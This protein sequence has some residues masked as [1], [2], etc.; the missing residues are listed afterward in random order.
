VAR[1]NSVC[2]MFAFAVLATAASPDENRMISARLT[3]LTPLQHTNTPLDLTIDFGQ[4]INQADRSGV[5][6]P[7]SIEVID[8]A[9]KQRIPHA[10]TEDFSYSDKGRIEFVI[11][12]PKHSVF[13]IRFETAN[14]RPAIVEQSFI[15]MIGVGDV[16]R[17]NA[18]RP[19]RVSVPYAPGLH[20]INGDGRLYLTGS[21]N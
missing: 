2:L 21:W 18:G 11:D 16:L 6:D 7:N 19:R 14:E 4:L 10:L 12:D 9:T 3:V 17:S 20:D 8:A 13:E 15:P 5:L 1:A